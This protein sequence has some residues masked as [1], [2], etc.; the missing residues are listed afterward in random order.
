MIISAS[1][2]PRG[3][4]R[5]VSTKKVHEAMGWPEEMGLS[6]V[7]M[8]LDL[9]AERPSEAGLLHFL[10]LTF[11]DRKGEHTVIVQGPDGKEVMRYGK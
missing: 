9:T 7:C 3:L 8:Q 1:V 11:S 6:K 2:R 10:E 4:K 5:G